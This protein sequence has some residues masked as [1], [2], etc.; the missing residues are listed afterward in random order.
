M[1]WQ[2]GVGSIVLGLALS[3]SAAH[4]D[5]PSDDYCK[6]HAGDS[7]T[8]YLGGLVHFCGWTVG[9]TNTAPVQPLPAPQPPSPSP[10]PPPPVGK[11]FVVFFASGDM[12]LNRPAKSTVDEAVKTA[13][14]GGFAKIRIIGNADTAESDAYV[15]S[16]GRAQAVRDQMQI[17]GIDAAFETEGKA[18]SNP[19]I[20]TPP[21]TKEALNR[22]VLIELTK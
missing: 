18:A 2:R 1:G 11:V 10:S 20:P 7:I 5:E 6:S 13:R 21:G 17:E 4:A 8:G 3:V 9:M 22:R 19:K 14:D 16:L 12:D 15:L